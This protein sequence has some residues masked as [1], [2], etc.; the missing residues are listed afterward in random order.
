MKRWVVIWGLVVCTAGEAPNSKF[1]TLKEKRAPIAVGSP[2]KSPGGYFSN[3]YT[4]NRSQ[5]DQTKYTDRVTYKAPS[6]SFVPVNPYQGANGYNTPVQTYPY[7]LTS[8]LFSAPNVG[9][10]TPSSG[11]FSSLY[12]LSSSPFNFY[13]PQ[14]D[15]NVPVPSLNGG[16]YPS[17]SVM[18]PSVT[19][20]GPVTFGVGHGGLADT[21]R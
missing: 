9:L 19:K 20:L 1:L 21:S 8:N 5:L 3:G 4:E 17:A 7:S 16:S 18:L 13:T 10:P 15:F 12:Q 6:N 2:Q 11:D 14:F